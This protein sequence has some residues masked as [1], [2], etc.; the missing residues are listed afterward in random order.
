LSELDNINLD[1]E[2]SKIEKMLSAG[3]TPSAERIKEY[4]QVSALK[5]DLD[6]DKV[7]SC[8]ADILRSEEEK[9]G[10]ENCA[11][12]DPVLKD[13]L[14]VLESAR[15]AAEIREIFAGNVI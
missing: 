13:I 10:E 6:Q 8:I 3:I 1:K 15:S 7:I 9:A 11:F 2:W 5:G 4:V 12:T 14:V